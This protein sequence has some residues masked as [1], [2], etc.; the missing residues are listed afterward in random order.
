M[1]T[2]S[3]MCALCCISLSRKS[4]TSARVMDAKG[5]FRHPVLLRRHRKTRMVHIDQQGGVEEHES[6]DFAEESYR[7]GVP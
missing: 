7:E 1:P 6:D 2:I 3:W 5:C 4:A